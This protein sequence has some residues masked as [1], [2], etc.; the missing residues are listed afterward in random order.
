MEI[1]KVSSKSVPN[2]I[3]GAIAAEVK[4]FG[5]AEIEA[6]GAAS[7]NQA[8]KAIAIA[9]GFVASTGIDLICSPGF[10]IINVNGEDKTA[11]KFFI[12]PR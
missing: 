2:K 4:E 6:I 7:I 8:V 5:K 9:R 11:I 12:G 1:L 3:A 10:T